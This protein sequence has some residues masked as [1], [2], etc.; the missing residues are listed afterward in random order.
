[1]DVLAQTS[2]SVRDALTKELLSYADVKIEYGA[3]PQIE[4]KLTGSDGKIVLDEKFS[5]PM[6]IMVNYLGYVTFRETYTAPGNYVIYLTPDVRFLKEAVV[7]DPQTKWN[8]PAQVNH[9]NVIHSETFV[10]MGANTVKDVLVNQLNF[11]ISQD[12]AT[13]SSQMTLQGIG[14]QNVKILIDGVPVIGKVFDQVDLSQLNLNNIEKIEIIQGPMSVSYG[15]NALGGTINIITKKGRG[16]QKE[17]SLSSYTESNKSWH[18]YGSYNFSKSKY[19]FQINGGRNF[20]GGWRAED[21]DRTWDWNLKEHYYSRVQLGKQWKNWDANLR[22]EFNREKIKDRGT[23]NVYGEQAIDEYFFTRRNDLALQIHGNLKSKWISHTMLAGNLYGRLREKNVVDLVNL[24]E[25]KSSNPDD[26]DTTKFKSLLFRSTLQK[27]LKYVNSLFGAEVSQEWGLGER[28]GEGEMYM[29]EYAGFASLQYTRI[30][31]TEIRLG[32]RAGYHSVY[33]MP[34]IPSFQLAWAAKNNWSLRGSY[35]KGFRAPSLKELYLNFVDAN[36]QIYGNK[37][38]EAEYSNNFQSGVS[39]KKTFNQ[40]HLKVNLDLFYNKI[41]NRIDLFITSLTAA[42]YQNIGWFNSMGFN[43]TTNYLTPRFKNQLGYSLIGIKSE[44]FNI[45]SNDLRFQQEIQYNI[46]Y[47]WKRTG[48]NSSLFFKYYGKITR[49]AKSL[50]DERITIQTIDPYTLADLT[51][52]KTFKIG[53]D[54]STGVK[55]LFNI[56][57][58]NT[59]QSGGAHASS[60]GLSIGTGRTYFVKI[61]YTWRNKSLL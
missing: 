51:L 25:K 53:I 15:T 31:Q 58:V 52:N 30:K 41:N 42:S 26:A 9:V 19:S 48:I 55:N 7:T 22:Y 57:N 29:G 36:H 59:T 35:A 23:P 38:L 60:G 24:T 4:W 6:Q 5:F 39:Y 2:I 46:Q 54:I 11:R 14:G 12:N 34:L 13:G 17:L 50:E 40:K 20:F 44:V 32:L 37:N 8:A 27:D 18:Q 45:E 28:I 1:M 47:E 10:K 56:V 33:S 3:P 61:G 16:K 21:I 43:F 49:A